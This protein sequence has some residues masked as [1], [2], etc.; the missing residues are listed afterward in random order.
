M[1][2][3]LK[4]SLGTA[5]SYRFSKNKP[6]IN[7]VEDLLKYFDGNVLSKILKAAEWGKVPLESLVKL[8]NKV[9]QEIKAEEE[10]EAQ[11]A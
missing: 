3:L 5:Y 1:D 10:K 9:V 2:E 7:T 4:W 8:A 11:T 6:D